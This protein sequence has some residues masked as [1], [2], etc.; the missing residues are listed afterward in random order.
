MLLTTPLCCSSEQTANVDEPNEY[1]EELYRGSDDLSDMSD[2]ESEERRAG[3]AEGGVVTVREGSA[4]EG[5]CEQSEEASVENTS[6]EKS[7]RALEHRG[8]VHSALALFEQSE[9]AGVQKTRALFEHLPW[10]RAASPAQTAVP[11]L[12]MRLHARQH[13]QR[14]IER[15]VRG[16]GRL[17][18][19]EREKQRA[20]RESVRK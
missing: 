17:E 19:R 10:E 20:K 14:E 5:K 7:F 12:G 9:E 18:A 2:P 11:L 4:R 8:L 15:E 3:D 13:N 6:L 1:T 16:G